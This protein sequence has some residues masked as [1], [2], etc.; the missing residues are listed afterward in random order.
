MASRRLDETI[1]AAL[2]WC[3]FGVWSLRRGGAHRLWNF[4]GMSCST[5]VALERIWPANGQYGNSLGEIGRTLGLHYSTVSKA[6]A[7]FELSHLE[8]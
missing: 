5:Q 6:I 4:A 2:R 3:I 8:T 1:P 7:R